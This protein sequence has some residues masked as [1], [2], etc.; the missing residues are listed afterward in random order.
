MSSNA[1]VKWYH[2]I[3]AVLVALFVLGPFAF[4]LLWKSPRFNFFWKLVLTLAVTVITAYAFW[5]S[6]Q[7]GVSLAKQM[8]ELKIQGLI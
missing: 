4:L 6:W 2:G 1:P 8:G 7:L 3:I 5:A